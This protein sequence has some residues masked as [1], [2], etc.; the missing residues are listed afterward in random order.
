MTHNKTIKPPRFYPILDPSLRPDLSVEVLARPLVDAGVRWVQLRMKNAPAGALYESALQLVKFLPDDTKLIVND[1]ADVAK[2]AGA[3]GVHLG[4]DDLLPGDA[5]K[6][7]GPEAIIGYSTH[8][9]GQIE[10]TVEMP[11]DYVAIGPVFPTTT[12]ENPNDIV[13]PD[14]L[15]ALRGASAHPLVA[16]G[17][18]TPQNS[19]QV[20]DNGADSVAV[21]SSWMTADDIPARLEE[22]RQALGRLD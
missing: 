7:L 15:A 21:I 8:N 6:I 17:G 11:V 19:M 4:Q 1:R 9:R 20:I 3:A 18:I 12:K 16:I 10:A 14:K 2:L 13:G 5:R 22:F